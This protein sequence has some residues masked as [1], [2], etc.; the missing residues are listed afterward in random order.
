MTAYFVHSKRGRVAMDAMDILPQFKGKAVHDGWASYGGYDCAHVLCNAHHLRELAFIWECYRQP[1]AVQM[2]LLLGTIKQHVDAAK[3]AGHLALD[4]EL[5]QAFEQRYQALLL[6]GLAANP[7]PPPTES[8]HR[9]R[10]KQTPPKNLLDRLQAHPAEVLGFM[11]DFEVPF[12]NNQAER[13]L[14]M[15]KLK[16][17]IS[18]G[19]RSVEGAKMFC[20]LRAYLSTL[21]KQGIHLLDA[22]VDLFMGN[23]VLPVL[24]AE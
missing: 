10:P 24:K 22:L 23:P 1:W 9:G 18:G 21:R 2:G 17:K 3:A 7:P 16:Q 20:R 5:R 8:P 6:Q 13:D 4:S 14:R 11:H 15:M 12:D 19:F